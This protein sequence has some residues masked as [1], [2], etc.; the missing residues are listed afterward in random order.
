MIRALVTSDR[1]T[2]VKVWTSADCPVGHG[3]AI[4]CEKS[5]FQASRKYVKKSMNKM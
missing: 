1:V 4:F 3:K 2:R 5:H